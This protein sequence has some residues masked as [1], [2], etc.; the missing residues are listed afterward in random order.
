LKANIHPEYKIGT[1]SCACGNT[2]QV[3]ST[4]GDFKVEICSACHPFFTGKQTLVDSAGRVEKFM[5][6]YGL[7][8]KKSKSTDKDKMEEKST[9][10]AEEVKDEALPNS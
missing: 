5:Q 8:D 4:V 6:K 1:V 9:S 2:F 3:R 10:E 7:S